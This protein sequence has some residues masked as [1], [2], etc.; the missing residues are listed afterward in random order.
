MFFSIICDKSAKLLNIVNHLITQVFKRLHLGTV[1]FGAETMDEVIVL[2][3]SLQVLNTKKG[4]SNS[5]Q[6]G[7]YRCKTLGCAHLTLFQLSNQKVVSRA[8]RN[9]VEQHMSSM[10]SDIYSWR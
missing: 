1:A 9:T 2:F 4:N 7:V 3:L 8:I 10:S 6:Y 5:L